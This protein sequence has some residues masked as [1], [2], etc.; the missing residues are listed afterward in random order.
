MKKSV[1]VVIPFTIHDIMMALALSDLH[2]RE[3]EAIKIILD[4]AGD[5]MHKLA[6][7]LHALDLV[8]RV[9]S[10]WGYIWSVEDIENKL[11]S[12]Y[13]NKI[14]KITKALADDRMKFSKVP[15]A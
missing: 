7:G 3:E 5:D 12:E 1:K 10:E 9:V 11:T 13:E 6:K 14:T 8:T 2:Y 4:L 15:R